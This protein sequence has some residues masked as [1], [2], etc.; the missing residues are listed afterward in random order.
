MRSKPRRRENTS[1]GTGGAAPAVS[2]AEARA[3]DLV[4]KTSHD[5]QAPLAAIKLYA[6]SMSARLT[7]GDGAA[8][9]CLEVLSLICA[10]TDEALTIIQKALT[11]E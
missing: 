2:S 4:A 9:E 5:L 8:Q 7:R 11:T 6:G 10:A 1:R 3:R